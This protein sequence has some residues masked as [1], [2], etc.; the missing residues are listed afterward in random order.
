MKKRVMWTILGIAVILFA[1]AGCKLPF[2]SE[3]YGTWVLSSSD[4]SWSLVFDGNSLTWEM[5]GTMNGTAVWSIQ[6]VDDSA[7][8]VQMTLDSAT[9]DLASGAPIGVTYYMTYSISG[10]S[11][12]FDYNSST[13]PSA[14]DAAA[15]AGP[16][17]KN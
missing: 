15:G 11:L 4:N 17:I 6:D 9:G 8:H 2:W 16:F 12:Y 13:Y 3:L 1:V 5:S 14:A 10:D 7:N